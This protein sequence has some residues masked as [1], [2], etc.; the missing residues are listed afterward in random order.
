MHKLALL[1]TFGQFVPY[2]TCGSRQFLVT[3]TA[4]KDGTFTGK[5]C[6]GPNRGVKTGVWWVESWGGGKVG[7]MMVDVNVTLLVKQQNISRKV[8]VSVC[9]TILFFCF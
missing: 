4:L 5:E 6:L 1:D 7:L 8:V 9:G 3:F 2:V